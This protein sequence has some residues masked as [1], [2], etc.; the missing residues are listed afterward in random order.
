[1]TE[2]LAT[3][4]RGLARADEA[5]LALR[6]SLT[7]GQRWTSALLAAV[8]LALLLVGAPTRTIVRQGEPAAAAT[9]GPRIA[10]APAVT[11]Q[12]GVPDPPAPTV[13]LSGPAGELPDPAPTEPAPDGE[14]AP[15]ADVP[16]P[17]PPED[18]GDDEGGGAPPCPPG[19]PLVV[20]EAGL[21]TPS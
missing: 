15:S 1:V 9:P 12:D 16:A 4:R 5:L 19:I 17:P 2:A 10:P 13:L 11:V 21:C 6:D 8:A 18:E 7:P 3:V 14:P 20:A